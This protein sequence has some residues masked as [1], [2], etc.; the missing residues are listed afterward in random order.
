MVALLS[1][2]ITPGD[3]LALAQVLRSP[4]YGLTDQDLLA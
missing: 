4:I 1:V 3:D 2:L